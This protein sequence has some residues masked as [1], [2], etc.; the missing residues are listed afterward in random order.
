M[1]SSQLS[2][3]WREFMGHPAADG[4][5]ATPSNESLWWARSS[6]RRMPQ[7]HAELTALVR[8]AFDVGMRYAA[9]QELHE[10]VTA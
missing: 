10:E 6:C 7:T 5:T 4:T 3:E 9:W 8:D 1:S 2:R